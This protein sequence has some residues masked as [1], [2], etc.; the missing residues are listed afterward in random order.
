MDPTKV[1]RR[2]WQGRDQRALI[3][4]HRGLWGPAPENSLTALN[5]AAALGIVEVDLQLTADN[6]VVVFHD[7]VLDRMTAQAG[8]LAARDQATLAAIP[9]RAGGGG[10]DSA[11]SEQ[12]IPTLEGLLAATRPGT[13]YDYD[14]KL[15]DQVEAIAGHIQRLGGQSLGSIKIDTK[16]P[17]DINRLLALQDR[18]GIMV[19]AKVNLATT[20]SD[21][22]R[23]LA[24][25]GVVAAEVWFNALDE[26]ADACT[27][28]GTQMAISTYTLDP[29][30]CCGLSDAKALANP[31]QVWGPLLDAGVTILMTD[32]A[33]ALGRYLAR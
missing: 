27:I 9:L 22:I 6:Q 17:A 28:A 31:D 4:V 26:L 19:M 5:D 15:P 20:G 1:F 12:S 24:N 14:I 18:F 30:H 33:K 8:P 11:Q 29:V 13:F 3:S 10:A 2:L 16:T 32:Q 25:A 7:D 21:H 23:D